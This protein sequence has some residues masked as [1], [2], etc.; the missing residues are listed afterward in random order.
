M[1]KWRIHKT[2]DSG[3][4]VGDKW[5]GGTIGRYPESGNKP[6]GPNFPL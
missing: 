1:K 4:G 2:R 3:K 5:G 6:A